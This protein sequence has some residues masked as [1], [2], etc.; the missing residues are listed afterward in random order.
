MSRPAAIAGAAIDYV[1]FQLAWFGCVEFAAQGRPWPGIG[2]VAAFVALQVGRSPRR[3]VD[4]ALIGIA[5]AVGVSWDSALLQTGV[6]R[7]QSPGPVAGMAPAWI[8]ALWVEL[9][10]VLRGPLRTLH[11]RP[12][13][14]AVLG[15]IGG[16]ASYAAA[17]RL[18]A[19]AFPDRQVALAVLA[20]GWAIIT[21]LLLEAA[22]RLDRSAAPCGAVP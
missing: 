4:V 21:P 7:Y 11:E 17:A 12:A 2:A 9:A 8:L 22:R 3:S 18:G 5:L 15:G 1:L 14:S 20:V 19:C 10:A 16:P 13:I 6:V